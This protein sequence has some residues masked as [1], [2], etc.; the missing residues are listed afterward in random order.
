MPA[1]VVALWHSPVVHQPPADGA[2]R[3]AVHHQPIVDQRG[4]G[5]LHAVEDGLPTGVGDLP[6]GAV[7]QGEQPGQPVQQD[8]AVGAGVGD[9]EVLDEGAVGV[10]AVAPGDPGEDRGERVTGQRQLGRCAAQ[11]APE[12]DHPAQ[13]HTV[14]AGAGAGVGAQCGVGD[15]VVHGGQQPGAPRLPGRLMQQRQSV[16]QRPGTADPPLPP[17]AIGLGAGAVDAVVHMVETGQSVLGQRRVPGQPGAGLGMGH[18]HGEQPGEA[19]A[20]SGRRVEGGVRPQRSGR[21]A[22][23]AMP[24]AGGG[25]GAAQHGGIGLRAGVVAVAQ[26]QLQPA[27]PQRRTGLFGGIRGGARGG[28]EGQHGGKQGTSGPR[29]GGLRV[30]ATG[31]AAQGGMGRRHPQ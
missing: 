12:R 22:H 31:E 16:Q 17:V 10:Q 9:P 24:G 23:G 14:G 28:G 26:E 29:H 4:V 11:H 5:P 15:K 21:G 13:V 27:A 7:Q 8:L 19:L 25:A 1:L 3:D 30:V 20:D 6:G 18:G 2:A